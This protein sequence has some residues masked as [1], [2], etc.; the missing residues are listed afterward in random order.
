MKNLIFKLFFIILLQNF[1]IIIAQEI[2]LNERTISS[3]GVY[4]RI[5][6]TKTGNWKDVM[7]DFMQAA[8]KDLTGDK[9]SFQYKASLFSIKSR[10]DSTLLVDY[11]YARE[12]FSRNFQIAVGLNLDNDYKFDGFQYGFDWAIVNKRDLSIAKTSKEL[13]DLFQGSNSMLIDKLQAYRQIHN[14]DDEFI[15]LKQIINDAYEKGQYI[16]REN[17]PEEFLNTLPEDYTQMSKAFEKQFN[18]EIEAI[19]MRPLLTVGF[20]SNFKKD[21]KF[22]D[23]YDASLVYLQ[24][25]TKKGNKMEIDFRNQ[26]KAKD[27]LAT[28]LIKRKEFS[29]QLGLNISILKKGEESLIEFKPNFEFK[30]IFSGLMEDEKNNQFLANADLRIKVLKN[31]WIPLVLKYDIEN[32]N[33]FGFLNISFNFDAIKN[34]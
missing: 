34:E 28:S 10:A 5:Q 29:S 22:L 3:A 12:T 26:F 4:K 21:A 27:S 9:K 30:R 2:K 32:N 25:L 31:L 19:R 13:E 14:N 7:T 17:L 6:E 24:G 18:D 11:N 8:V 20:H 1:T 33:L 15:R 16:P 23:E